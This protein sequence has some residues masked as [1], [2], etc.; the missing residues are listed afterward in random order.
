MEHKI[1]E[2]AVWQRVTGS[3]PRTGGDPGRPVLLAPELLSVWTEMEC[4]LRLLSQLARSN[5]CYS[6]AAQSQRQQTARLGGLIC[7]M[8]GSSPKSEKEAP[9]SGSRTQQL[10]RLLTSIERCAARLDELS[11]Q[12]AGLTQDALKDLAAQQRQ[13]WGQCLNLLGQLTMP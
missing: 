9:P 10:S 1:D 8:S 2:A 11:A 13:Q 5:R 3:V 6:A 12:A 7:L 4:C